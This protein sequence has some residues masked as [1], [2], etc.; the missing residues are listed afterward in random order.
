MSTTI[1]DAGIP[2]LTEVIPASAETKRSAIP[3]PGTLEVVKIETAALE[4]RAAAM[5]EE[6]EWDRLEREVR[7]RVLLQIIENID[8]ILEQRVRDS[9]AD[10]L[11]TSVERLASEIK[12]GLRVSVGDMITRAVTNEI[13]KLK[14][15]NN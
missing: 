1:S 3:S 7:E 4:V 10:V 15:E 6:E 5:L 14:S 12:S 13:A 9:L 11:Q 2:L 8:L